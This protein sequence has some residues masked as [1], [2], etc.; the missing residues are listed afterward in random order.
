MEKVYRK[1]ESFLT[2][3]LLVGLLMFNTLHMCEVSGAKVTPKYGGT[4]IVGIGADPVTLNPAYTAGYFDHAV[5][6]QIYNSLMEYDPY[7]VTPV[8]ELA[9]SWEISPDGL[10]YT[11]HL[12]RNATW[13]DGVPFTSADVIY[14]FEKVII[15]YHPRG[16]TSFGWIN[17][18]APDDYT[19][20]LKL[21]QPFAPLINFFSLWYAGILPKHIYDDPKYPDP[22]KNPHNF[23]QL[24][25]IGTGPFKFVEWVAGDHITLERNP[26]YWRTDE[27][28][29]RL[30][31]LDKIIFKVIPNP[32]TMVLAL[33]SG[34]IDYIPMFCPL[35]EMVRLNKTGNFIGLTNGAFGAMYQITFNLENPIL[36]NKDVRHAI[37]Y[38]I[39]KTFII[40]TV[41]YG[42]EKVATGPIPSSTAWAYTPNVTQYNYNPQLAEQLLDKAGYP[43]SAPGAIDRFTVTLM[44]GTTG[45]AS[46]QQVCEAVRDYLRAVGIDCKLV[47]YDN[48]VFG[49]LTRDHNFDMAFSGGLST[50]PDPNQISSFYISSQIG[51]GQTGMANIAS[52]NNSVIDQLFLQGRLETNQT[53]RA[54]IYHQIQKIL[55]DDLP[56]LHIGEI[57]YPH[58]FRNTFVGIPVGPYGS[59]RERQDRVWWTLGSDVSPE[60]AAQAIANAE[61]KVAA[62]DVAFAKIQAAKQA[63]AKGDYAGAAKLAED[64]V[65]AA[66]PQTPWMLYGVAA[67]AVV[68]A[69]VSGFLFGRRTK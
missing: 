24:P 26:N 20:V 17:F 65:N 63:L 28:G 10:T 12:V 8:P 37:A 66:Q 19:V 42:F 67:A 16:R 49:Q 58:V 13:H 53:K 51:K 52:Y 54:E 35:N 4:F 18:S 21:P 6:G 1:T 44:K 47:Q 40:N 23:G 36:A 68:V 11:F 59:I 25:P 33:E 15:P 45:K 31:Y 57:A 56:V 7:T 5:A 46:E 39:N 55:V 69:G 32:Q 22:T 30:P 14:T 50:A 27:D 34:E 9:E 61:T 60:T 38:A 43:R 3:I 29:R 2:A 48:T 62:Q 41:G 64:A